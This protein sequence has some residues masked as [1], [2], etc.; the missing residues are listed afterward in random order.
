MWEGKRAQAQYHGI[1][2]ELLKDVRTRAAAGQLLESSVA[3]H[4][5]R[6]RQPGSGA[7]LS[8]DLLLPEIAVFF[9][10]GDISFS[11]HLPGSMLLQKPIYQRELPGMAEM[12]LVHHR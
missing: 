8:D 7:P 5:L 11:C 12:R 3:G 2:Q 9:F 10:A 6:I 4:L 1:M